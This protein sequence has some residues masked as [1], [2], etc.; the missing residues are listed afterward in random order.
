MMIKVKEIDGLRTGDI[1]LFSG[2][3]LVS[4]IIRFLSK[5]KWSH[6]GMIIIDPKYDYPLIYEATKSNDTIC[7]DANRVSGVQLTPLYER[8]HNYNGSV[9]IRKLKGVDLSDES[10]YSLY[11]FKTFMIGIAFED[12]FITFLAAIYPL[13]YGERYGDARKVYC[14]ELIAQCYMEMGLLTRLPPSNKY[15]PSFFDETKENK[16]LKGYL[17][18]V[19]DLKR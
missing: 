7:L 3:C 14:S 1:V 16:L 13:P 12:S 17:G 19:R 2:K 10:L 11:L 5:S 8:V 9:G 6:V 4:R 18:K 15:A